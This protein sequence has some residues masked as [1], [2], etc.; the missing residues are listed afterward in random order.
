VNDLE[1]R[2]QDSLKTVG[3]GYRPADPTEIRAR[4]LARRRRR[5]GLYAGG[6]V[7]VGATAALAFVFFSAAEVARDGDENRV[8][9]VVRPTIDAVVTATVD[10]GNEPSGVAAGDGHV[11]VANSGDDSVSKIDPASNEVVQSFSVPGG[12]DDVI[13]A[14]GKTWVATEQGTVGYIEPETAAMSEVFSFAEGVHADLAPA[15]AGQIWAAGGTELVKMSTDSHL[16]PQGLGNDLADVASFGSDAWVYNRD[17]GTVLRLDAGGRVI[18]TTPVG[19]S[20]NADL[21]ATAK[22]AWLY[23]G[24]TGTLVQIQQEDGDVV[25]RT[26]LG[27]TFGAVAEEAGVVYA[28]VTDGGPDGTGEGRLYRIDSNTAERIGNPIPLSDRPYD[29]EASPDGIWV[30]NNSGNTLTKIELVRKGETPPPSDETPAVAGEALFYFARGGDI[31]SYDS[32]GNEVAVLH[33][34]VYE[35]SPTLSPDGRNLI[36]QQGR[37]GSHNADVVSYELGT[38]DPPYPIDRGESP[39]Y[40]STGRI[41]WAWIKPGTGRRMISVGTPGTDDRVDFDPDPEWALGPPIVENIAWDA[42]GDTIYWESSYEGTDLYSAEVGVEVREPRGVVIQPNEDGAVYLSP[43]VQDDGTLAV[44]RLCCGT[45]PEFDFMVAEL[46][47]LTDGEYTKIAGLDD[48]GFEPSFEL[49]IEPAGHLEFEAESG[50]TVG[51]ERSWLVGDGNR[52]MLVAETGE[53][54]AIGVRGATH[55][56]VVP[57]TLE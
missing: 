52:L 13:V 3:E 30:T 29:V 18:D 28:M 1:R 11:W 21:L 15:E 39:A 31:F 40:S 50:W 44:V 49:W 4:F 48:L 2:L 25:S 5:L 36:V 6:V 38:D 42:E 45:Y 51:A 16:G 23:L 26:P 37:M 12:P 17:N 43:A 9:P 33:S 35:A 47:R 34:P 20:R 22:Y 56:T 19:I 41:A 10:V 27:G 8:P 32:N 54:D 7:F 24:E 14:G 46:G 55:L 57:G 53:V